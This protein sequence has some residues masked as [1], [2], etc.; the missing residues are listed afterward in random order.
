MSVGEALAVGG[1]GAAERTNV[2][3]AFVDVDDLCDG[4]GLARPGD[5]VRAGTDAVG[6]DGVGSG[7]EREPR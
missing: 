1:D 3:D 6:V 7:I 2:D 4:A 5:D